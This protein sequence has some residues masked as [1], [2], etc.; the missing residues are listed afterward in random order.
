MADHDDAIIVGG[1]YAGTSLAMRL[2][3]QDLKVFLA[4]RASFPSLPQ[5]PSSLILHAGSIRQ[6]DELGFDENEYTHPDGSG[7]PIPRGPS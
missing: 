4:D 3:K 5:V 2:A 7:R 6:L 1:R